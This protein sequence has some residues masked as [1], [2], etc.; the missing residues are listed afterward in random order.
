MTK[1]ILDL[2]IERLRHQVAA[3]DELVAVFAEWLG[4]FDAGVEPVGKVAGLWTARD[5]AIAGL[6]EASGKATARPFAAGLKLLQSREFFRPYVAPVFEADPF[7]ILTVALGVRYSGDMAAKQW[8]ADLAQRAAQGET[9]E[10]RVAM[11]VGAVAVVTNRPVVQ[12]VEL[13]VALATRGIG[14]PDAAARQAA[15]AAA[16]VLDEIPPERA[17]VRL[18]ALARSSTL[19]PAEGIGLP[20]RRKLSMISHRET[21]GVVRILLLAANPSTT[22]ELALSQEARA[23]HE[24]LT[25]AKHRDQVRL[26]SRWAVRPT[27]LQLAILQ[28]RPTI[29]QF[30]GHGAGAAGAVLHG[31]IPGIEHRVSGAALKQ[32]FDTLKG[33]IRVVVL[34]ACQTAEHAET[35]SEA[36]DF[37]I[38]MD[39]EI[40]DESARCFS[41]EFYLGIA[42]GLS[43]NKAF[44][45]G[46]T[47][48]MLHDFPDA[49][50]PKLYHRQGVSADVELV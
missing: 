44:R 43:V 50:V 37:V 31:D 24:K 30:S 12:P 26:E 45:M 14:A 5:V 8:I 36:V 48:V 17:A 41:A 7:A 32:M 10:W 39:G 25:L 28:T 29:V 23:I 35:I 19:P 20:V 16:L 3:A 49:H 46:V 22:S 18:A 1:P 4:V 27:D 21:D 11:L 2:V 6:R 13:V 9:E 38:G 42:S 33:D 34:N 15:L 47:A 40:D